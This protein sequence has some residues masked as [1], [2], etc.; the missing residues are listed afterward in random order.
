VRTQAEEGIEMQSYGYQAALTAAHKVN[1]KVEDL[2]G[3]DK[4]LDFTRP[5]LPESL[6]WVEPLGFLTPRE[7]LVLNQIR[8]HDYLYLFGLVEEFILPFVLDHA[9]PQLSGDDFRVRAL[10]QFAGEEAKHIQLFKLFRE[11]FLAGFGS[12]C[13]VIGPPAAIAEAILA[14][15]PLSVALVI[16][17][18]EW[19]TQR[20]YLDSVRG[21]EGLDPQFKSLLKHHWMEEAQHAKLDTLMVQALA[22][23]RTPE[24]LL[25]AVDGYLEIGGLLDAGLEQQLRFDLAAFERA[26]GRKLD[27]REEAELTRVQQRANRWTFLGSGMTHPSFVATL[28]DLGP[29]VRDKVEQVAPAFC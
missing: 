3:G 5:F 8:G 7:R 24:Q 25:Q 4:R 27:T 1:W 16:A 21:D 14:K 10:L 20:H 18:I 13:E 11:D 17:H 9:R 15:D 26:T 23:G 6:A 22:D 28:E 2:I 12:D 19:M 29:A